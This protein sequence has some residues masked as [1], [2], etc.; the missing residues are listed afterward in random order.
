MKEVE[1]SLDHDIWKRCRQKSDES[2]CFIVR[3]RLID[4]FSLLLS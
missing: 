4:D 1:S 2:A 3:I